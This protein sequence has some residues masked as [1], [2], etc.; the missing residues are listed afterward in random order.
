MVDRFSKN[1]GIPN[2]T[3]IRPCRQVERRTGRHDEA[4]SIAIF[5]TRLTVHLG[6]VLLYKYLLLRPLNQENPITAVLKFS[7]AKSTISFTTVCM[8]FRGS[9]WEIPRL[10]NDLRRKPGTHQHTT[11]IL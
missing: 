11:S 9:R 2:F 8:H 4:Q 10:E 7:N 3:K 5:R 1:P 6:V